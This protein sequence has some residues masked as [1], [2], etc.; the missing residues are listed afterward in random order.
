[1]TFPRSA[2]IR[3]V[4]ALVPDDRLLI[5]TDSPYLAPVPHRG[6]R[7]E[8]AFVSRVLAQVAALRG[9]EPAALGQQLVANFDSLLASGPTVSKTRLSA[10]TP[11]PGNRY[12]EPDGNSTASP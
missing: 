11:P 4:A 10:L 6:R 12:R 7:N 5:E 2:D 9:V 3:E 1:M 8:P